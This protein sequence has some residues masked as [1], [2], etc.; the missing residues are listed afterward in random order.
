MS[1]AGIAGFPKSTT[2][3]LFKNPPV[4]TNK[5]TKYLVKKWNLEQSLKTTSHNDDEFLEKLQIL[6]QFHSN[7]LQ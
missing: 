4:S 2:K 1:I 3:F 7:E 6:L 5:L